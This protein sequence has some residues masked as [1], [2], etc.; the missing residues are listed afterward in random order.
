MASLP[1]PGVST[2]YWRPALVLCFLP[3]ATQEH[4]TWSASLA[5]GIRET[6]EGGEPEPEGARQ[7]AQEGYPDSSTEEQ[8]TFKE[9]V[10]TLPPAA[11]ALSNRSVTFARE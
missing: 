4:R 11:F 7:G 3:D 8:A 9:T 6:R 2:G 10:A 5:D 1:A